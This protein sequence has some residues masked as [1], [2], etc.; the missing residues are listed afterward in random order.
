MYSALSSRCLFMGWNKCDP[1][2][3]FWCIKSNDSGGGTQLSEQENSPSKSCIKFILYCG[4]SVVGRLFSFPFIP[5]IKII[6]VQRRRERRKSRVGLGLTRS[7]KRFLRRFASVFL[8]VRSGIH[9]MLIICVCM[10]F[11]SLSFFFFW[12]LAFVWLDLISWTFLN[13]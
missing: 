4:F 13:C 6:F 11:I 12:A 10:H 1:Y 5:R 3:P 9:A 2:R 8:S 7:G